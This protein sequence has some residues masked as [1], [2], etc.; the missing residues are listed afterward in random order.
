MLELYYLSTCP[1]C[2]K[3]RSYFAENFI[4]Y[5]PKDVSNSQY[6]SELMQIGKIAQVPF[7]VDTS[8]DRHMYDSDA[9]ID[10]VKNNYKG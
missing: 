9:I 6:Y 1:Y 2:L 5:I 10:Y 7:L 3:V 8:N 4:D